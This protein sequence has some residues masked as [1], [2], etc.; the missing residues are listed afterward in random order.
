MSPVKELAERYGN[1]FRSFDDVEVHVYDLG[2]LEKFGL[3][4]ALLDVVVVSRLIAVHWRQLVQIG[5]VLIGTTPCLVSSI[6][7]SERADDEA[8]SLGFVAAVDLRGP[9]RATIESLKS[10]AETLPCSS[11]T[12]EARF[13]DLVANQ[14]DRE[15]AMLVAAGLTDRQIA[16]YVFLSPQTVRN[17]ISRTLA[18]LGLANRTQLAVCYVLSNHSRSTA[19]GRYESI[20][21]DGR[22]AT[23]S[24][25]PTSV[26]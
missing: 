14:E 9:A 16:R 13:E 26:R 15:I 5:R 24:A 19:T 25:V 10:K 6:A 12:V 1:E 3:D 8:R 18:A 11:V 7:P 23:R 21:T 2:D 17:R 20:T 4:T 22:V